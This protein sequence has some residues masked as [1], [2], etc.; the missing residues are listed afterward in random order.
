MSSKKN[1]SSTTME[2]SRHMLDH[3]SR[4][5]GR[6]KGIEARMFRN[7][8]NEQVA[9]ALQL[10][11]M[12]STVVEQEYKELKASRIFA[13]KSD[14]GSADTISIKHIVSTGSAKIIASNNISDLP[15]VSYGA[16]KE[17]RDVVPL[18]N[19]IV[20]TIFDAARAAMFGEPLEATL[21]KA[22]RDSYEE[23]VESLVAVGAPAYNI[24]YGALN[25]PGVSIQALAAAG[26]WSTK[27]A[28]QILA[29]VNGLVLG[30]ANANKGLSGVPDTLILPTDSYTLLSQGRMGDNGESLLSAVLKHNPQI[31]RVETWSACDTAGASSSQRVMLCDSSAQTLEIYSQPFEI[32]APQPEGFGFEMPAFGRCAGTVIHKPLRVRYMDGV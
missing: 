13:T 19:K 1:P 6:L 17:S 28:A 21:V 9:L 29:D 31:S 20:Y 25:D 14:F 23:G 2:W 11:H 24:A 26:A 12:I 4:N 3:V 27:T 8:A 16:T 32:L 30:W 5:R 10:E 18:G 22:A 15:T 7:D